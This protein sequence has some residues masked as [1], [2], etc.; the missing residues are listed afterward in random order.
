[1][2]TKLRIG[3]ATAIV[4]AIPLFVQYRSQEK[5]RQENQSLL[6]QV[7]QLEALTVENERLSNLVAGRRQPLAQEAMLE[8]MRLRSE[9][10]SL[11]TDKNELEKQRV[12]NRQLRDEIQKVRTEL[13]TSLAESRTAVMKR[14]CIYTLSQIDGAKAQWAVE[15]KKIEGASTAG[16]ENAI[17]TFLPKEPRCP[18]NGIYT[19]G[20]IGTLP[21]CSLGALAGH[22]L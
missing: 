2:M 13:R 22:T 9:V 18:G 12:E 14:L 8:L 6:T 11:R 7:H 17:N 20:P 5:L 1:M 15:N 21:T 16:L 10:N 4:V 19:Y 3:F